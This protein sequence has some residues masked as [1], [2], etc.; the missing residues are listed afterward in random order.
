M[1]TLTTPNLLNIRVEGLLRNREGDVVLL[2]AT[3]A[4]IARGVSAIEHIA[5]KLRDIR[6]N[7]VFMH[8]NGESIAMSLVYL[9]ERIVIEFG[10]DCKENLTHKDYD[11]WLA[12]CDAQPTT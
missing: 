1:V 9:L 7:D 10:L 4:I 6:A 8:I 3:D 2:K 5:Q 11:A 12:W